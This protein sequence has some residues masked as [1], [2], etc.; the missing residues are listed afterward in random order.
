MAAAAE[1]RSSGGAEVS[2]LVPLVR[3]RRARGGVIV[4]RRLAL[5][6]LLVFKD[7]E[8]SASVDGGAAAPV[9]GRGKAE[10]KGVAMAKEDLV[11]EV[12]PEDLD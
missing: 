12:D 10:D 5:A 1:A 3:A 8:A 4:W 11:V 6:L 7:E 2:D 9:R